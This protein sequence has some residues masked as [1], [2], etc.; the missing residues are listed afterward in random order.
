M[1]HKKYDMLVPCPETHAQNAQRLP[2]R[3]RSKFMRTPGEMTALAG[4]FH[5]FADA[6]A[7]I[8][9]IGGVS[10]IDN[11]QF[12]PRVCGQA[13]K[14]ETPDTAIKLRRRTPYLE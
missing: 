12:I 4:I 6:G 13:G 7:G 1:R 11:A 3:G 9:R 5:M 2:L 8:Y 10:H 14:I